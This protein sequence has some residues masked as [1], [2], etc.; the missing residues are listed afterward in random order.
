MRCARCGKKFLKTSL[1]WGYAY[2]GKYACSY[3]CMR[4]M[5]KEAAKVTQDEKTRIDELAAQGIEN[6]QIAEQMNMSAQSVGAYLGHKRRRETAPEAVMED[7]LEKMAM[8][9]PEAD[10]L[11]RAVIRL[12]ADMVEILKK[13]V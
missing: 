2:G 9:A 13:I 1:G 3:K 4:E 12:M 8:A 5:E 7:A 11:K 6:A 10:D